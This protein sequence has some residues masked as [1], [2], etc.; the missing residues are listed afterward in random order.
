[1]LTVLLAK[2]EGQQE[3]ISRRFDKFFDLDTKTDDNSLAFDIRQV[4]D[5]LKA[6]SHDFGSTTPSNS[7]PPSEKTGTA[8]HQK[9]W[10]KMIP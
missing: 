9:P 6:V 10:K 1:M 3:I 7:S 2:N 5:D 8:H 4:I